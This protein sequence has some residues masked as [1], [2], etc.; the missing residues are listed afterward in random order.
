MLNVRTCVLYNVDR[1][2]DLPK[3]YI[4]IC[5][6]IEH[7]PSPQFVNHR[8]AGLQSRPV[9]LLGVNEEPGASSGIVNHAQDDLAVAL[10]FAAGWGNAHRK[11]R[12]RAERP[13]ILK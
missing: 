11:A 8:Q 5:K 7:A 12:W 9:C 10:D 13:G 3:M 1:I 4:I 2:G 6:Q